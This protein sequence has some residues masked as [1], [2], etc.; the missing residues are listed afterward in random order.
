[1]ETW[2][3]MAER[4]KTNFEYAERELDVLYRK[5]VKS[6]N[7]RKRICILEQIY[8]EQKYQYMQCLRLAKKIK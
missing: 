8:Y 3:K 6:G 7:D 4:C 2:L 1:M 5:E